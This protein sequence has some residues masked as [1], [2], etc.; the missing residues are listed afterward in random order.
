M[1]SPQPPSRPRYQTIRPLSKQSQNRRQTV[2]ARDNKTGQP[3]VVKQFNF[4]QG[5]SDWA[6]ISAYQARGQQLLRFGHPRIP[7]YLA[8]LPHK[9]GFCVVREAPQNVKTLA[10]LPP[11]EPGQV[12]A[13]AIA[14]LAVLDYIHNLDP[15]LL[16]TNLS[17]NNILVDAKLNVYLTDFGFPYVSQGGKVKQDWAGSDG[18]MPQEQRRNQDLTPASDLYSLGISLV[19]H[20]AQCPPA[21]LQ[22]KTDANGRLELAQLLPNTLSL[23]LITWLERM[24][25]V[26]ARQRFATAAD[27]SAVLQEINGIRQPEA[28]LSCDRLNLVASTYG[29]T[30]TAQVVVKN[31]VP[32]TTLTGQWALADH[33]SDR[34]SRS[35]DWVTVTEDSHQG[36]EMV[37]QVTVETNKLLTETAYERELVFTANT[38]AETH[39]L[40]LQVVTASLIQDPLILQ[41]LAIVGGVG[42][43]AGLV[44]GLLGR[45]EADFAVAQ[46][47]ALITGMIWGGSSGLGAVFGL[48]QIAGGVL[49]PL[50]S[51]R[52]RFVRRS[53]ILRFV[54]LGC[55]LGLGVFGVAGY[56]ARTQMGQDL[57]A[58]VAGMVATQTL[59][60]VLLAAFGVFLGTLV[61]FGFDPLGVTAC[62]GTGL[63]T[64]A[65]FGSQIFRQ[66]QALKQY[67][68][69]RSRLVKP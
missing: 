64:V 62:V 52:F 68:K 45:G 48:W 39:T 51:L 30:L 33:P 20:L 34:K 6:G 43:V 31:P 49:S 56:V 23:D 40:P 36:N 50:A 5:G 1:S 32:E 54:M 57:P 18:V 60:C 24:T 8:A 66:Q 3:V 4:A 46:R 26:F 15:P 65:L 13:V 69:A 12:C 67:Q 29:E 58:G 21:V 27:A 35:S 2:L 44:C 59:R 19:C 28:L 53:P 42:L 25:E 55:L 7:R 61:T 22:T 37:Y 38:A 63:G 17:P 41:P 16:H 11:L 10:Q 47:T 14:A 9:A